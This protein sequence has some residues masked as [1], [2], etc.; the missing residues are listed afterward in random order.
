MKW[1]SYK[2]HSKIKKIKSPPFLKISLYSIYLEGKN[3]YTQWGEMIWRP[4]PLVWDVRYLAVERSRE[5]TKRNCHLP[6]IKQKRVAGGRSRKAG[7]SFSGP[8]RSD[9]V[10]TFAARRT[11]RPPLRFIVEGCMLVAVVEVFRPS[12][13]SDLSNIKWGLLLYSCGVWWSK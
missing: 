7:E 1:I 9:F 5:A 6:P 8:T 2:T 11:S 10:S 3:D 12:I 13:I 4:T